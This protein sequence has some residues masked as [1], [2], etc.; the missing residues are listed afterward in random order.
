MSFKEK[1]NVSKGR[2]RA[3][4]RRMGYLRFGD[5]AERSLIQKNRF[6]D[7]QKLKKSM[8]QAG[9]ETSLRGYVGMAIFAAIF[10]CVTTAVIV[11]LISSI[12]V[13]TGTNVTLLLAFLLLGLILSAVVPIMVFG[14]FVKYPS[15]YISGRR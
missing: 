4:F 3:F 9:W 12:L 6:L 7:F 10:A 2:F 11:S 1:Q 8:K 15:M 14:G 5:W 13:F